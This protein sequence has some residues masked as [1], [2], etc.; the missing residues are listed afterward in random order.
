MNSMVNTTTTATLSKGEELITRV[1][2]KKTCATPP[3]HCLGRYGQTHFVDGHGL[4]TSVQGMDV[5][6]ILKDLSSA[7]TWLFW[8]LAISRDIATNVCHLRV[9]SLSS[10]EINR[11]K[12]SYK[13]LKDA[14]L[15][16]RIK[17]EYYL[18][19]PKALLPQFEHYASVVLRWDSAAKS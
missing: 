1:V 16:L 13:E 17:P 7:G 2:K 3:F 15:I 8:T 6:P 19:N 14:Q 11:V 4:K 12:K 10:C 9:A 5:M 18:I